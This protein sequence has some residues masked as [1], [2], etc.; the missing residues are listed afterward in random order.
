MNRQLSG[1][2]SQGGARRAFTLVELLVVIAIIGILVAL[3]L[4]AVQAAREA[5]RRMQ[6]ANNLKQLGLAMHMHLDQQKTYPSNG[7]GWAW[8]GD[9]NRGFGEKQ[10]GSFYMNLL[11]FVEQQAVWDLGKGLT[12]KALKDA[13]AQRNSTPIFFTVCPTR[14]RVQNYPNVI[15]FTFINANISDVVVRSDYA[16]NAGD[17]FECEINPGPGSEA[18]GDAALKGQG[19]YKFD[20]G[21]AATGISFQASMVTP[22][23]IEDGTTNTYML[24]EKYIALE[25]YEVG[26][27]YGDN[28]GAYAG[29]DNDNSRCA[30]QIPRRDQPAP[31]DFDDAHKCDMGSV[32]PS[33][34]LAALCDGSVKTINFDIDISI[35]KRYANR[36]DG[37]V[38]E[39]LN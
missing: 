14:R 8:G 13:N 1:N 2:K 7:W 5:G 37:R 20:Q 33:V 26:K 31:D 39:S 3:L 11:P 10:P 17:Q 34:W 35:H 21:R 22:A 9:P 6:C 15:N 32:H 38:G 18:E 30:R 25:H 16:T 28:E 12:G 19:G 36:F 24:V 27:N 29:Y 4:P 23:D